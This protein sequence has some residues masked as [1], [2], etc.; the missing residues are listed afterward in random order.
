MRDQ[1]ISSAARG[2]VVISA[3]GFGATACGGSDDKAPAATTG[4]TADTITWTSGDFVVPPDEDFECFYTDLITD[5][6]LS[7]LSA[8]AKQGIGGHHVSVYYVDNPRPPGRQNC[9]GN[10][11][12]VD[13][14]FVVGAGG[15]GNTLEGVASLP[16]GLAIKVPKGKQFMVQTHYI[17]ATGENQTVHDQLIVHLIDPK[18][19][20]SYA[21]DFVIDDDQWE[22][23]PQSKLTST[24]TCTTQQ[25]V[26][27]AML[28]G[29]M[30]EH[31]THYTL[32]TLDAQ[33]QA[34]VVYDHDWMPSYSSH[35]PILKYTMEDP[36]TF[37]AGTKFRQTC[38]WDN[39]SDR[40]L[41]FPTEM[42]IGFGYY[43]PGESRLQCERDATP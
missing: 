16:P 30:H 36:L 29:H 13:W 34:T 21:S 28:L 37:P 6:E 32:E 25:E 4:I 7:V 40:T 33:G 38:T 22:L 19:V 23:A 26:K 5:R 8:G 1:G 41:I 11:E 43:F 9:A 31:G 2:F 10:T 39:E 3:L 15:E 27:L 35:P 12:M 24:M 18:D 17:N 14:H 42:C 20:K